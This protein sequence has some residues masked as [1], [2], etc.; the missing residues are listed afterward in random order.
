[1][2]SVPQR[3]TPEEL[4]RQ[5]QAEEH[6]A[7]KGYLKIVLG[8]ASGVGKTRRIFEEARRRRER[9]QDVVVGALQPLVPSDLEPCLQTLEVVPMKNAVEMDVE[10]LIRRHP[11]VCVIDGLAYNNPPG[12]RNPA[13]WMDV[14]ALLEAGIKVIASINIQYVDELQPEVE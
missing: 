5:A 12:A 10:A 2:V 9:G 8:Y 13:R 14:E 1:M 7:S 11:T 3:R 6:A 4:L